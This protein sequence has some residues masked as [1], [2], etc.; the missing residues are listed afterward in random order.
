[1]LDFVRQHAKSWLVKVALALIILVF[2]F[3][4]GYAYHSRNETEIA[5]VGEHYISN[6]EFQEAYDNMREMYKR[7][8]GSSFSEELLQKMGM[9]R[10]LLE[11][12]INRYLVL[13]GAEALGLT[14]TVDEV[15]QA[16][17]ELPV[18]AREGGFDQKLYLAYLRQE[19]VTPEAFEKDMSDRITARKVESFIRNTALVTESEVLT[20]YHFNRDQIRL[21]YVLVDPRSFEDK[22][23]VDDAALSSFYQKNLNR[24]MDPEKREIAHVLI[25]AAEM[26]KDIPVTDQEA[27]E[28]Y[29]THPDAYKKEKEVRASHI[30]FK[31]KKDASEQEVKKVRSE[32]EKVLEQA[33]QGKDFA[34]LAKKYSQDAGSAKNGGE[35]GF[36]T[37]KQMV[38]QFADAAF[39]LKPGQISGLVKT[40]YG[41]HIIKVEEVHEATTTPFDKVKDNIVHIIKLQ[42]GQD[43]AYSKARELRDLAYA[44][45]DIQKAA[46]ELNLPFAGTVWID[47]KEQSPPFPEK[48]TGKLLELAQGEISDP[49]EMPN[50]FEVAQVKMIKAPQQLP[51]DKVKD[52]VAKDYRV[53]EGKVLAGKKA[54]EIL[55][56]AREKNSLAE[57][58]GQEKLTVRQ[59]ELFSR[60][61]PD[62]DLKLLRGESLNK[63]FGL[64]KA[65]PFPDSPLDLGNRFV[66]CQL[67]ETKPAPQP[68][69]EEIAQIS[70]RLLQE[71]QME[72][73]QAWII[74]LRKTVK[75]E[76][77]KEV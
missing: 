35:L 13:Q 46:Q 56:L 77:F 63:A 27:R 11:G 43:L 74:G 20:S 25:S 16:I 72:L 57:A 22:V 71:K 3:W 47:A 10:Q 29:N 48:F 76:R 15:R 54:S 31:L 70:G 38:P 44:R 6:A 60:E 34:E 21:A 69:K 58:A 23:A 67:Q 75:I 4:G 50:G 30:L 37:K 19:G 1:M 28:Y 12:L 40:D 53:E 49:F 32:A 39:S 24:Y 62:K 33:R 36:F 64:N 42:K 45:K 61:N 52:R 9:K 59:S 66:V 18:F 7:Q 51:L 5:K 14:A 41:F 8:M 17:L 55:K 26:G 68:S 2:I 73:W 65:N